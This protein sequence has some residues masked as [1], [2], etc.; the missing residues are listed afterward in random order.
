MLTTI[1][2]I[3]SG[4][5]YVKMGYWREVENKLR[6]HEFQNKK[7]GIIGFGRIGKNVQ[8]FQDL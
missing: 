1:K 5:S 8:S 2:N 6:S 3:L 4:N 7:I